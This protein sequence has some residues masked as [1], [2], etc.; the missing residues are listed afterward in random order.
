MTRKRPWVPMAFNAKPAH[1]RRRDGAAVRGVVRSV[2]LAALVVMAPRLAEAQQSALRG[3]LEI[4]TKIEITFDRLAN[5]DLDDATAD[6]LSQLVPELSTKIGYRASDRLRGFMELEA[7]AS[8]TVSRGRD[9][10]PQRDETELN[11]KQVYLDVDLIADR[12]SLRIG[13]QEFKDRREWL[14]DEELD[15]LRAFYRHAALSFELSA[16][17]QRLFVENL[18][19][20]DSA[21]ERI[22]RYMLHASYQPTREQR[23]GGY[24]LVRD[25]GAG[26]EEPGKSILFGLSAHG[27]A[28][29]ALDYWLELAALRGRDGVNRL[30]GHG[31]DIGATYR[32][33]LR[34]APSLTLAHAF[35]SGDPNADDTVDR[36]FRQT[37]LQDNSYRFN[38]VE[39]FQLYGQTLDP[40]LSNLAVWTVGFG[41]RPS[42][43][44]SVDVIYHHY[45]QAEA[46]R[47]RL[48]GARIRA[49]AEG[50][51]RDVG[52]AIDLILA[53]H[54]IPGLRL[55]A[56]LGHFKPGRAFGKAAD[57]AWSVELGIEYRF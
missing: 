2:V 33:D 37:G 6:A 47:G 38:G 45:R 14:Y 20:G 5:R 31:L 57:D 35:G 10:S 4:D 36:A 3:R 49:R 19:G 24:V 15:G 12:L 32:F 29:S 42:P 22:D 34:F 17:R 41:V 54:E 28:A 23:V 26:T 1:R 39:N 40:E 53:Y 27:A 52:E 50:E 13:R 51:H 8:R 11:L 44:S 9:R 30:H 25:A 16:T 46:S 48:R 18:L 43:R 21:N 7:Q 55:R 56:R